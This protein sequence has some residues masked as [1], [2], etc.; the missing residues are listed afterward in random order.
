MSHDILNMELLYVFIKV[1]ELKSINKS[2]EV[3]ALT[4]PAISKKI[5][6]LEEYYGKDL[7]IRSSK[8]MEL[9]SIGEKVYLEAKKLITHAEKLR[10]SINDNMLNLQDLKLGTLDSISSYMY[11]T[12][13]INSLNKLKTTLITNKIFEL[14]Q[15]FN[16]GT[17]DII[18]MDSAF[19]SELEG[20]YIEKPLFEEPYFLVYSK[21]NHSVNLS[22]DHL[23]A[24]D[25]KQL[26]L[27]MYPKYCPIH[28]RLIQIYCEL[29][30]TPPNIMEIDYSDSTIAMVS[31]SNYVT[32]LPES[33]ALNKVAS[34]SSNLAMKQLDLKFNRCV[35][36]FARDSDAINL[37]DGMLE[38]LS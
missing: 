36:L 16:K 12:F 9:N 14:V 6:Q 38:E 2:S 20:T 24:H 27:I 4:Q 3:L 10:D 35:S 25:L 18:L 13:F 33:I 7:F 29:D 8:G 31:R 37:I 21:N 22:K 23:D 32:V 15:P 11:P 26:E 34:D 5:K 19:K 30:I 28:Q 1:S 17:L